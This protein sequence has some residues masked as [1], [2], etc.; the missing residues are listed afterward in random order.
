[1]SL[2]DK[3]FHRD[4]PPDA[5]ATNATVQRRIK[6]VPDHELS[7]WLD[8]A[9]ASLGRNASKGFRAEREED[10][11]AYF[12]EAEMDAEASLLMVQE[13]RARRGLR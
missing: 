2:L 1:M 6:A 13:I 4:L 9:S 8:N 5:P 7:M 12:A 10:Q 3:L 11:A